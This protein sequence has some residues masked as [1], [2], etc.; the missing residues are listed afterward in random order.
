MKITQSEK[1]GFLIIYVEG[2]VDSTKV[3]E[4]GSQILDLVNI[5]TKTLN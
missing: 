2:R 4:F 5:M 1:N 3:S